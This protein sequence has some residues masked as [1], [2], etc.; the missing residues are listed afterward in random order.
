M[1]GGKRSVII[2]CDPGIDDALAILLAL[3]SPELDVE[4]II[5]TS[6]NVGLELTTQNALKVLE[7]CGRNEVPPVFKGSSGPLSGAKLS[8][9]QVHGE[10]GLGGCDLP[11]P[12]LRPA[13]ADGIDFIT[14]RSFSRGGKLTLICLGPLTDV[15]SALKKAK[16]PQIAKELELIVMGG[17]LKTARDLEGRAE[18]NF[19]SDPEA[20]KIV[21]E[22]KV[23]I[24]LVSIDVTRRVILRPEHLT[25][26]K[27]Y[28][29][30]IA[31]FITA[32]CGYSIDYHRCHR[33][34][35]GAYLNDPLAVGIAIDEGLGEFFDLCIDVDLENFRG[36]TFA[37]D[38]PANVK[39]LRDVD[40][41]RFIDLFL[42]RIKKLC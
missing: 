13:G 31:E 16:A 34:V 42:S 8:V 26:F 20:A 27:S 6:G 40:A 10:D 36:K 21:L 30:R 23:P 28:R 1:S 12:K 3:A 4:A 41:E 9:R 24:T 38:G 2:D 11:Q 33:G 17:A 37:K 39:F 15:A 25:E 5:T 29:S 19:R 7:L 32:I 22:S 35:E 18:F 14:S